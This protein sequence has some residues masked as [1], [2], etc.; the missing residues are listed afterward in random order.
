MTATVMHGVPVFVVPGE[1]APLAREQD[2]VDLIANMWEH[3]SRMF[4]IP[5]ERLPGEF[6]DLSTGLAGTLLQKFVGYR[7]RV[8]ILGDISPYTQRSS[9][10]A[11]LV[12]ESNRGR[13]VWFLADLAELDQR[14]SGGAD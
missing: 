12:N 5:V 3:G 6:F 1:G 11:S 13:D 2:A 8:V 4:V 10:L 9:A 7:S 14:L